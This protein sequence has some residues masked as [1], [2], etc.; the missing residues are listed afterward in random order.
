MKRIVSLVALMLGLASS[1]TSQEAWK[2]AKGDRAPNTESRKSVKG[3][4][5]WLI[6]TDGDW[7][8]KWETSTSTIPRFTEVRTV[9]RGQRICVLTFYSN[10]LLERGIADITCDIDILRP[11]GTSVHQADAECYRG[12]IRESPQHVFISS[13]VID[14]VGEG[15]DPAGRWIVRINLKD[16][17]RHVSVPLS[18]SF[19]LR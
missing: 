16:N 14:F 15:D 8:K 7:R 12:P 17:V 4:G 13:Q 3:F 9:S 5:G 10:P 2:S 1:A 18:N 11:N 19:V 6:V